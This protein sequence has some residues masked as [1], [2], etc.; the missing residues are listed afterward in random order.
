MWPMSRHKPIV[1]YDRVFSRGNNAVL[2]LGRQL[3]EDMELIAILMSLPDY[4]DKTIFHATGKQPYL[5]VRGLGGSERKL[6]QTLCRM[7]MA[8]E[9]E[10]KKSQH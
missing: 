6:P 8:V 2:T 9:K 5:E 7:F 10:E 4:R 1:S 3:P